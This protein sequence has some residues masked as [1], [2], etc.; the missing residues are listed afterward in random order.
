MIFNLDTLPAPEFKQKR[1]IGTYNPEILTDDQRKAVD[2]YTESWAAGNNVALLYGFAGSGKT[3]LI[4]RLIEKIL[5][6]N[7]NAKIAFCATTN[8]AV[9]VAFSTCEFNDNR[10]EFATIHSFLA[11]KENI[12]PDGE[13][14]FTPDTF[15]EPRIKSYLS[16]DCYVFVDEVSMLSKH[17]WK[18]ITPYF[19][20]KVRFIFIGDPA[21]A[22]PVK[23]V[24]SPVFDEDNLESYGIT[25]CGLKK[26]MRQAEG[27]PI[28]E[29]A[30]SVRK[31]PKNT[32]ALS[33]RFPDNNVPDGTCGYYN[34]QGNEDWLL[35]TLHFVFTSEH[36]KQN[37]N[38][39][40]LL[41]WRNKTVDH[42]NKVI[43]RFIYGDGKLRRIEIGEKLVSKAPILDNI[44]GKVKIPNAT[45]L[46][47]LEFTK[48]TEIVQFGIFDLSMFNMGQ[49]VD[50]PF[51]YTKVAF[52]GMNGEKKVETIK[53]L[54]DKGFRMMNEILGVLKDLAKD[55]TKNRDTNAKSVWKDYYKLAR[56]FA[57]VGYNYALT[58]HLSQGSTY[59]NVIIHEQDIRANNKVAERNKLLYTAVTRASKRLFIY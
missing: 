32:T 24:I 28:I 16:D 14:L 58:V 6:E 25:V 1:P 31:S 34:L 33:V 20:E 27:N 37:H 47:V 8:K 40:K 42:Y 43:R 18:Y 2:T 13:I 30:T 21:Q 22:P 55:M 38:F 15:T 10:I 56:I 26:I 46:T 57:D 48:D 12:Q 52:V 51:Y 17:L 39:S 19:S 4:A 5:S 50:V 11:L 23:E 53:V 9:G 3:F 36:F 41:C 59:E 49:S 54:T 7:K 35:H 29:I 44:T 45:E